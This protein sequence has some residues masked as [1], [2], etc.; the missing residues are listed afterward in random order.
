MPTNIPISPSSLQSK[1]N[2]PA[3][4]AAA[5]KAN[6]ADTTGYTQLF[7]ATPYT[8]GGSSSYKLTA[9]NGGGV[10][11]VKDFQWTKSKYREEVP[12]ITLKELRI[13][14][15]QQ[16][17]FY[18]NAAS[19]VYDIAVPAI[20]FTA[21]AARKAS[22]ATDLVN[23]PYSMLYSTEPTGFSYTFPFY[24]TTS[25]ASKQTWQEKVP[26][27]G[28]YLGAV[29]DAYN[30][31]SSYLGGALQKIIDAATK[32]SQ[33]G[34]AAQIALNLMGSKDGKPSRSARSFS[35]TLNSIAN[36]GVKA[37]G[38]LSGSPYAGME[39]PMFFAGTAKNSYVISFPL[40]N[41][42]SISEIRRNYDFIRL[43]QYQNLL[44]RTSIATY[45]PPV[46]YKSMAD[47]SHNSSLGMRFFYVSDFTVTNLGA[48]R[49]M[50]L[51]NN[52]GG[53]VVRV[54][55]PEAYQVNI[56]LTEMISNSKNLYT[57]VM[58]GDGSSGVKSM[59]LASS[60]SSVSRNQGMIA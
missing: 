14:G 17:N 21:A 23:D 41:T 55:I 9:N 31:G 45:A 2:K 32:G 51:G 3:W 60:G 1:N 13:T 30:L 46:I 22:A 59:N 5:A 10:N 34:R 28:D 39:Q 24:N 35:T 33:G 37:F 29:G 11:V 43:F 38:A 18:L 15:I 36:I 20:P 52:A 53:S 48:L 4:A 19:R 47:G 40:F 50:N 56:T 6:W 25:A 57:S 54:P 12:R 16:L 8:Y 49:S 58:S 27:D 7:T 44:E 26:V 42:D